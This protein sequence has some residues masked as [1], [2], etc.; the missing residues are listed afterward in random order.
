[1]GFIKRNKFSNAWDMAILYT[2]RDIGIASG[3][4]EAMEAI[5]GEV[6]TVS[7][8]AAQSAFDQGL[9]PDDAVLFGKTYMI[10][11]LA[12]RYPQSI[13]QEALSPSLEETSSVL[14]AKYGS[15]LIQRLRHHVESFAAHLG[16]ELSVKTKRANVVL[17]LGTKDGVPLATID[18]PPVD[19]AVGS[20]VDWSFLHARTSGL[21]EG[22]LQ[23]Q[24]GP[25]TLFL[26]KSNGGVLGDFEADPSRGLLSGL[27]RWQEFSSEAERLIDGD[28]PIAKI[29][30]P[31]AIPPSPIPPT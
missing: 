12:A 8:G 18:D 25:L 5:Q 30:L 7:T 14:A 20:F 23:H 29:E 16:V 2:P 6:L 13:K 3:P 22:L 10:S 26:V 4:R 27:Q 9:E 21:C 1:M 24:P 15:A 31:E 19:Q 11:M 17:V 28:M